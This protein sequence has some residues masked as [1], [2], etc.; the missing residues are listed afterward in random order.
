MIQLLKQVL[1]DNVQLRLLALVV[2]SCWRRWIDYG[3][4]LG[5]VSVILLVPNYGA[6]VVLFLTRRHLFDEFSRHIVVTS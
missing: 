4:H 1:V 5:G 6:Y 3:V 2:K